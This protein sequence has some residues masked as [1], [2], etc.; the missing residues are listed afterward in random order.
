MADSMQIVWVGI[1]AAGGV[2]RYLDVYLRSGEAPAFG[3]ALGHAFVSGFSGYMVAL[4]V[5]R[6]DPEWATVAAGAGGYLGTQGLDWL[7]GVMKARFERQMSASATPPTPTPPTPTPP[8]P[9]GMQ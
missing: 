5:I 7:S 1:A 2:V 3:K 9:G 4:T 8:T 6:F